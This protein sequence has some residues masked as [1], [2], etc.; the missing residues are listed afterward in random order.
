MEKLEADAE[1]ARRLLT[2]SDFA[3]EE[4]GIE[5]VYDSICE[6]IIKCEGIGIFPSFDDILARLKEMDTTR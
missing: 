2:E 5:E 1:Y 6:L 4:Y 3:M